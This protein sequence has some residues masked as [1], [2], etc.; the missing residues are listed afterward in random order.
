MTEEQVSQLKPGDRVVWTGQVP[1]SILTVSDPAIP[2]P[3]VHPRHLFQ[4]HQAARDLD[5]AGLAVLDAYPA[6]EITLRGYRGETDETDH[7]VKWIKAPRPEA[8]GLLFFRHYP[9]LIDGSQSYGVIDPPLGLGDGVD[10]IVNDNGDPMV[11]D[12]GRTDYGPF[13]KLPLLREARLKFASHLSAEAVIRYFDSRPITA[14]EYE[15]LRGNSYDQHLLQPKFD[16]RALIAAAKHCLSN[17]QQ[18]RDLPSTYDE[19]MLSVYGP[20]LIQRLENHLRTEQ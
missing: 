9:D 7:L 4:I 10:L 8:I 16:D 14:E 12:L 18:T 1:L 6:Y 17:C 19:A 3:E 5:T 20:M 11:G 15:T 13:S 2:D